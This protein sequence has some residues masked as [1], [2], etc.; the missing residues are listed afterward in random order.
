MI[1]FIHSIYHY[2]FLNFFKSPFQ[3]WHQCFHIIRFH[4][5]S[6]PDSNGRRSITISTNIISNMF[7][8]KKCNQFLNLVRI[9]I[10]CQTNGCR[11]SNRWILGKEIN[12]GFVILDKV[13]NDLEIIL[14]SLNKSIYPPTDFAHSNASM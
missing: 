1:S 3:P 13:F 8:L 5:R 12:P 6:T 11:R 4:S 9:Q 10:K 14:A 7:R 2:L